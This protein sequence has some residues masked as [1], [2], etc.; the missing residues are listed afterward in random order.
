MDPHRIIQTL[1]ASLQSEQQSEA[2]KV[3][4][5]VYFALLNQLLFHQMHKIIGFGP[6]LLQIVLEQSL[7]L[8]V[9]QAGA[10]FLKNLIMKSWKKR[11]PL[12]PEEPIPFQIHEND[13]ENIRNVIVPAMAS[14]AIPIQ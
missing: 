2:E 13:R 1:E 4:V 14:S 10:V 9:R 8:P 3:L 7:D 12:T 6:T 5:E 11:E